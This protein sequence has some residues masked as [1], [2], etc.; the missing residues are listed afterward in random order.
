MGTVSFAITNS[1]IT[2]LSYKAIVSATIAIFLALLFTVVFRRN[3]FVR[4]IMF[5]VVAGSV[6][7]ASTVLFTTAYIHLRQSAFLFS[8]V[9]N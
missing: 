1:I 8:V 4:Q 7:F 2:D 6:I 3:E 5:V 9:G